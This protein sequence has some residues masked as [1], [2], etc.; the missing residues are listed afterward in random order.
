MIGPVPEPEKVEIVVGSKQQR[1]REDRR[2]DARRVD[3]D[4]Q[5][6]RAAVVNLHADLTPGVLDMDLAQRAFHEHH[7]GDHGDHH[8]QN[9]NDHRGRN[10][11]R[12]ALAEELRQSGGNFGHDAGE[13]DQRGA[14]A[15]AAR[16]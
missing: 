4:R 7:G 14:V 2:D 13:D 1:R 5:M 8:H 9:A 12:A 3:L 10:R 16:R 6:R 11:A 15:D